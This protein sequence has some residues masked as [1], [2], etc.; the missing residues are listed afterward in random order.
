MSGIICVKLIIEDVYGKWIHLIYC[1]EIFFAVY[2]M[3]VYVITLIDP[4]SLSRVAEKFGKVYISLEDEN[5]VALE[6]LRK[7]KISDAFKYVLA[8]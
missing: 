5:R 2:K 1:A 4:R 6:F 3:S 7:K 8:E